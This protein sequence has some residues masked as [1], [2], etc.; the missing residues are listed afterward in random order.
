MIPTLHSPQLSRGAPKFNHGAPQV[1]RFY[2]RENHPHNT[3]IVVPFRLH[4][5]D[6][7]LILTYSK[8]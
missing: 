2:S 4:H 1:R 7:P 5:Q 3:T 6:F 8:T